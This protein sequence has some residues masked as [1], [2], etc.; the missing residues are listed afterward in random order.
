MKQMDFLPKAVLR[1]W[2]PIAVFWALMLATVLVMEHLRPK[3]V[4]QGYQRDAGGSLGPASWS[5]DRGEAYM[6]FGGWS[7][8]SIDEVRKSIAGKNVFEGADK[9]VDEF[10]GL[11]EPEPSTNAQTQ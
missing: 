1:Y 9:P 10:S 2:K 7:D 3:W 8:D 4:Y 11:S 5:N 6:G